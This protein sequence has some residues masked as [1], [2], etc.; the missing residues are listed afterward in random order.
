MRWLKQEHK[1]GQGRA[2]G[3]REL[4]YKEGTG[5]EREALRELQCKGGTGKKRRCNER[6]RKGTTQV[7]YAP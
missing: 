5:A 7:K 2:E 4:Q 6:E 1:Q 3:D